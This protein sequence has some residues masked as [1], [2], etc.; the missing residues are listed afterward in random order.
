VKQQ[1]KKESLRPFGPVWDSAGVRGFCREG[2]WF[3]KYVPGLSFEGSTFVAKTVTA[4]PRQG[5]TPLSPSLRPLQLIPKSVKPYLRKDMVL[6]SVG[7]SNPGA[8]HLLDKRFWLSI[9]DPFLVSFA[10]VLPE[11]DPQAKSEVERFVTIMSAAKDRFRTRHLALQL[12]LSC[13]NVRAGL[14]KEAKRALVKKCSAILDTLSALRLPVVVKL[15]LLVD[16]WIAMDIAKHPA[17]TGLCISNSIPFGEIL[18]EWWWEEHFPGGS[19]LARRG[20]GNGGLSG[21]PLKDEVMKWLRQFR[22]FD[23]ETYV[24]AGGGIL[25]ASDV[26]DLKDEGADSVFVGSVAILKP[27]RV[28]SVIERAH[29]IF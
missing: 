7:L 16:P 17:C 25:H 14:H 12:N 11:D 13:P 15:N 22:R 6:N 20:F 4:W 18:P 5:N 29:E 8:A 21:A 3:H 26:D 10:P 23:S 27:W 9:Q 1:L 2:Y 24:N 28:R 19:P